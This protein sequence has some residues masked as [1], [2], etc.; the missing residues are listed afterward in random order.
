[1]KSQKTNESPLNQAEKTQ[2][3]NNKTRSKNKRLGGNGT[4]K[5]KNKG[6]G[7]AK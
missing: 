6:M 5:T 2:E 3:I 7:K 4:Q 1:M